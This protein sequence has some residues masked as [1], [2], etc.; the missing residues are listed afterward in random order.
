MNL[1]HCIS[2]SWSVVQLESFKQIHSFVKT[3]GHDFPSKHSIWL[4]PFT[5]RV[6]ETWRL[7]LDTV[8][9]WV[10][11]AAHCVESSAAMPGPCA[12][13]HIEDLSERVMALCGLLCSNKVGRSQ[14]S[15]LRP[16]LSEFARHKPVAGWYSVLFKA[17]WEEKGSVDTH[18]LKLLCQ[19]QDCHTKLNCVDA[20]SMTFDK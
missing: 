3:W 6:T 12:L 16:P 19:R 13:I 7:E 5:E 20:L 2:G 14:E 17:S 18:K 10:F 9:H 8:C 11:G 15:S 1:N 4:V